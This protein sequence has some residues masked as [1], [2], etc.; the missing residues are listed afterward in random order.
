MEAAAHGHSTLG[1]SR[2]VGQEFVGDQRLGAGVLITTPDGLALFLKRGAGGD[3]AGTWA[4]PGGGIED[5]ETPEEAARRET[6]EEIGYTPEGDLS[7]LDHEADDKSVFTT[8]HH[9]VDEHF[10]PEL[11]GEHTAYAWAPLTDPPQPLH[12]GVADTIRKIQDEDKLSKEEVDY[13]LGED[14][15]RCANCKHFESPSSCALVAG[16]IDPDYWCKKFN[17]ILMAGDEFKESDHPRADNGQFGSG[18]SIKM[19]DMKKESGKMGSNPGGV[20]SNAEGKKFYIKEGKTADHVNNELLAGSLYNLAGSKTLNYHPVEGGK[21]IATELQDLDKKNVNDFTPEEKKK[22]QLD[23]ATHAWLANWDAAGLGG[24]NQGIVGG[25][26]VSLDLGGALHYRGMGGAKGD[27]FGKVAG[28]LKSMRDKNINPDNAKLFGSMSTEDLRNSADKVTNISDDSIRETVK[29]HGYGDDLAD[30]LIDRKK[31]IAKQVGSM[32]KDWFAFDKSSVRRTDT[33]GR[34]HVEMTN[35]SKANVCPYLGREIPAFQELGL[36]PDQIYKLYRDPDELER[37]ATTFDNIPVLSDHV[38]VNALDHRPDLI[39]GTTG[40]ES[41]FAKPFLRN[42]LAVWVKDAIDD[43]ESEEKKELSSAYRYRA[44]MTP[45]TSPEGERYDGVM[46]DIIGNHVALVK[47][48]RAGPD[49]VV[50]DSKEELNKMSKLISQKATMA[51]GALAVFLQPRLAVDAKMP[52]LTAILLGVNAKNFAEKKPSILAGIKK[53]VEGKLAKDASTEGLVALLDGLEKAPV[54]DNMDPTDD[55]TLDAPELKDPGVEPLKPPDPMEAIMT[56]LEGKLSPEDMAQLQALVGGG[57]SAQ[58]DPPD[59]K[60]MPKPGGKMVG[61]EE[62]DEPEVEDTPLNK[63]AMDAALE[64]VRKDTIEQVTKNNRE[65][66]EA[67]RAVRPYVGEVTKAFDSAADVYKSTLEALKVDIT[68]CD[69]SAYPVLLKLV[70]VPGT[71]TPRTEPLGMDASHTVDFEK[72]F[73]NASRI[74]NV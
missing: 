46:R 59:F 34:L 55:I 62:K 26:P 60:G 63:A 7:Q 18:S 54:A 10:L 9:G 6:V 29:A 21:H 1:I 52:S 8:F 49:V 19:S 32:A 45:G 66:R 30:K 27:K 74:G 64:K 24:D 37:A 65:I 33:D 36:K 58:D 3:H 28:E 39:I 14:D 41:Q 35:I 40:S 68:G 56:F 53:A 23:F 48:G 42:S 73:P 31:D 43:I 38:E 47:E 67:E 71:K 4:W 16:S 69:P 2:K 13:S 61:D 50:G 72:R 11:N 20:Y 51:R 12:P 17:D 57:N 70:P 22:A 5:G 25:H 15:D 44:D